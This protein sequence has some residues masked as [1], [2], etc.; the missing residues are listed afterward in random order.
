MGILHS[1]DHVKK[2]VDKNERRLGDLINWPANVCFM[3]ISEGEEKEKGA[4]K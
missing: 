4:R 2:D 3:E 1:N